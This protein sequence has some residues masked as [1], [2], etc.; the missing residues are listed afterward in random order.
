MYKVTADYQPAAERGIR[1]DDP[2]VNITWPLTSPLLS[3]KDRNLP[4]L[5]SA[6]LNFSYEDDASG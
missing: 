1:W 2:Q 3:A 4:T 6:E 5:A